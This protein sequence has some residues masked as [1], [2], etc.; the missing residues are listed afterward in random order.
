[1]VF[2]FSW[3][4]RSLAS[5]VMNDMNS[6][7]HSWMHSRASLAICVWWDNMNNY[8]RVKDWFDRIEYFAIFGYCSF[9]YFCD[10][11][12]RQKAILLAQRCV[13]WGTIIT[14]IVRIINW[15]W[16]IVQCGR[17]VN[18]KLK[19]SKKLPEPSMSSWTKYSSFINTC[20]SWSLEPRGSSIF[21]YS[22]ILN[23]WPLNENLYQYLDTQTT[24]LQIIEQRK[25][26]FLLR[27]VVLIE[28]N[29]SNMAAMYITSSRVK[30]RWRKTRARA[31]THGELF[32]TH[33]FYS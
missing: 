32:H 29:L 10:I 7:T 17:W 6:D 19:K 3:W 5:D 1:M 28:Q 4:Q 31:K 33:I 13:L 8:L 23:Y 11:C 25:I 22:G 16:T 12:D 26:I 27:N 14:W 9:H 2:R 18:A 30:Q 24:K 20:D 21:M 15:N